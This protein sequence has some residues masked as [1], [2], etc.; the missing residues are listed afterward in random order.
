M[1]IPD[2]LTEPLDPP[3]IPDSRMSW[4]EIAELGVAYRERWLEC[5]SDKRRIRDLG[6]STDGG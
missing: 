6:A 4:G 5:E 1:A 3:E 2:S